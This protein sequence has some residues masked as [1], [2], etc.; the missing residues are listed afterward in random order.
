MPKPSTDEA[1]RVSVVLPKAQL[2]RMNQ[3][4]PWGV[5]SAF[6]RV[7]IEDMIEI[8][9]TMTDGEKILSAILTKSIAVNEWLRLE[10]STPLAQ[11]E[12]AIKRASAC[13]F[14]DPKLNGEL[15]TSYEHY[16]K[17]KGCGKLT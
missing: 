7:C 14:S 12:L 11:M 3:V 16:R 4:V 5:R 13:G 8:V 1:A 10:R 17:V 9:T 6:L 2:A 15:L